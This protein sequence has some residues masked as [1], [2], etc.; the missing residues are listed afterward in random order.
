M[1]LNNK[2][3]TNQTNEEKYL[4]IPSDISRINELTQLLDIGKQ[5]IGESDLNHILSISID[6][7]IEISGAERGL[8]IFFDEDGH[9]I[10][11]TARNI[12]TSEIKQP[13]YLSPKCTRKS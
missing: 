11:E 4:G 5:I 12:K 1:N 7:A 13:I 2:I 6:K 3:N 10:F 9:T 8:I